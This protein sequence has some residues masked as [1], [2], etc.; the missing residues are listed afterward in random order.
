[1][2][3]RSKAAWTLALATA[4][5]LLVAATPAA[6]QLSWKSADEKLAFKIGILGQLSA[7]QADVAGTSDTATNLFLRR[8][9]ILMSFTL[10]DKLSIFLETDSPNLGKS[11]NA[12]VKDSGDVFLQ[13]FVATYKF[14][15]AF[16]LDGGMLLPAVSYNHTQSA[17]SLLAIDYGPYSFVESGPLTARVGRDYGLRARGYLADNHLE[18]RA[19]VYQGARGVNASNNLRYVGRLMY[20]FFTP[21]V[22]LFYRGTSLGKTKTLS[23]GGSYDSQEDYTSTAFDLFWDQPVGGGNGFVLQGD[24]V[25]ADGDV[26]LTS[27]PKQTNTLVEA[28]FY[29]AAAKL[30]PFVQ[31]ASQ[32]FDDPT[33][34]DE[35]RTTIGLAYYASGHNNNFKISYTKI[36]PKVGKA[37]DQFNLQWQVFQF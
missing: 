9:R 30:Q 2:S 20:S 24:Y 1:M 6:A 18:Y 15:P 26:F 29:I 19:G 14:S 17:A 11:N 7:E 37:R 28:G 33:R 4:G 21:Q 36:D 25:N 27:L 10:G 8:A 31:L 22:G 16:Q 12:G 3:V 13:D 5:A 34:V 35:D 23:I 32:D